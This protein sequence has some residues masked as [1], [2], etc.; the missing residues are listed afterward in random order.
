[1]NKLAKDLINTIDQAYQLTDKE[2]QEIL[3]MY[4]QSR[5]NLRQFISDM[6][7]K[8]GQDG[9]I[10]FP[11]FQ[12]LHMHEV[13]DY[14]ENEAS[15]MARREVRLFPLILGGAIAYTYYKSAYHIEQDLGYKFEMGVNF[16]LLRQEF[17]D[18]TVNYNWS[19][20]PF[21]ERI[22]DNQT[23]LVK[24]LRQELTQ[25]LQ[26][27]ESLD[28]IARRINKQFNSK[29]Y[30][31]QRLIVTEAARVITDAQ[32]QIYKDTG[33]VKEVMWTATLEDNTCEDCAELDGQRFK[34]D[35]TGKPDI[36][37]HPNCRCAYI[38]IPFDDYGPTKRK[39]NISKNNIEYQTYSDWASEKG[40]S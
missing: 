26:Q 23:Y 22:W 4:N 31:S 6:F 24:S 21:S 1:M 11:Q 18:T 36:P 7:M 34:L 38:A 30:E 33:I 17:I 19:G 3:R 25:G 10:N 5:N 40:I 29:A 37:L 9:K 32:E 13:E 16:N 8:Y 35:D 20:I 12:R 14:I 2:H 27:G 39:D 28:K 15:Q